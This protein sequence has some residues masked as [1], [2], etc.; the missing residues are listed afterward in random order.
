[1]TQASRVEC[2]PI[3]CSTPPVRHY[4]NIVHALAPGRHSRSPEREN[5]LEQKRT[6]TRVETSRC[7]VFPH[8]GSH[9]R[10]IGRTGPPERTGTICERIDQ[11]TRSHHREY[12]RESRRLAY[13]ATR[14]VP[15]FRECADNLQRRKSTDGHEHRVMTNRSGQCSRS[16]QSCNPAATMQCTADFA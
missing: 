3:G 16:V 2:R 10:I 5:F 13:R 1:M 11:K 6:T 12:G 9:T 15:R 8:S 4:S 7:K 14:Y